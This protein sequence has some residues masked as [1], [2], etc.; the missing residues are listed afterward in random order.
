MES[1]VPSQP[2]RTSGDGW[3][4]GL[5][6]LCLVHCLA[7]P[8][9]AASLPAAALLITHSTATHALLLALALPLGLVVLWRGRTAA[10]P[11]PLRLGGAGFALMAG[12]I[13]LPALDQPLTIAG[14]ALV[15]A[16]H[17]LNW[18]LTARARR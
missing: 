5:S 15:M 11:W 16:G 12:A 8:L 14:V 13:V 4:I 17:L 2:Q 3:A 10:G 7:L 9:L 6:L 1:P 18:R